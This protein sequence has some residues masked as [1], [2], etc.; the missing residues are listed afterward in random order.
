MWFCSLPSNFSIFTILYY[1]R[2]LSKPIHTRPKLIHNF[3]LRLR[4]FCRAGQRIIGLLQSFNHLFVYPVWSIGSLICWKMKRSPCEQLPQNPVVR[5][6]SQKIAFCAPNAVGEWY[7]KCPVIR[8]CSLKNK[9]VYSTRAR[10]ALCSCFESFQWTWERSS[11]FKPIFVVS[12]KMTF[13]YNSIVKTRWQVHLSLTCIW[14]PICY[15]AERSFIHL[16]FIERWRDIWTLVY[17][18]T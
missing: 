3:S 9:P 5:P 17:P 1:V 15:S 7:S 11:P 13:S 6:I 12:L 8:K 4:P 14:V 2:T 16:T 18:R 10:R